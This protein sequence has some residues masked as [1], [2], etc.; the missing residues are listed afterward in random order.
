MYCNFCGAQLRENAGFCSK[1]GAAVQQINTAPQQPAQPQYQPIYNQPA[2]PYQQQPYNQ[3]QPTLPAK[4]KGAAA[5]LILGIVS[6]CTYA[7]PVIGVVSPILAVVGLILGI[8]AKG[9]AKRLKVKSVKST[10]G[11]IIAAIVITLYTFSF[12]LGFI[13]GFDGA[14]TSDDIMYL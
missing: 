1:C 9:R 5:S 8:V 13:E 12:F 11:I 14:Y 4:V 2:A 6:L 10:I 3:P 7:I